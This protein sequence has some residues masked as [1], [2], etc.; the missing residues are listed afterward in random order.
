M[1]LQQIIQSLV[2]EQV[3]KIYLQTPEGRL[4]ILQNWIGEL[5]DIINEMEIVE[6]NSESIYYLGDIRD[7]LEIGREKLRRELERVETGLQKQRIRGR[8]V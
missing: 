8:L 6:E 4:Q 2:K 7:N 3:E 5:N 1:N